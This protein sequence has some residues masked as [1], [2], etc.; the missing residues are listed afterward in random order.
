MNTWQL[1]EDRFVP[2]L[3]S[4]RESLFTIA[5]G[6]LGT[7]GTF[8]EGLLGEI[9]ATFV[10]GLFVTP[11]GELPMLGAVPDWSRILLW[12]DGEPLSLLRTPAGYRRTLDLRTGVLERSVLWKGA[13]GGVVRVVFRRLLSMSEPRLAALEA[14]VTALTDPVELTIETGID[15]TVGSPTEPAWKPEQ[16]GAT[17]AT[18]LAMDLEARDGRHRL[19]V[20]TSVHG[21]DGLRLVSDPEHP[22]FRAVLTLSPGR[23]ITFAKYTTFH[24]SQDPA[25]PPLLPGPGTTFDQ[26][27]RASAKAWERRWATSEL[28]VDGDPDSELALRFAAFQLIGAAAPN[29]PG[30]AIGAKLMSGFGYR[31]HVFW[32]TDIFVVPYFTVT[33]PDLARGHLGYRYRG[34][35]GARRKAAS[36]GRQGAFYAWESADTGDETT[37]EWSSPLHGEQVRIWTGELEEHIVADVAYTLDHYWRWSG[38]DR[39]MVEQGAEMLIDGAR[40]W[41]GRLELDQDGAHIRD[42]IGPDEYH[43]HVADSYFTNA[44]AAWHLRRAAEVAEW[45]GERETTA[46]AKMGDLLGVG[47]DTPGEWR[48]LADRIVLRR[49]PGGLWE[50]HAGFFDLEEVDLSAFRPRSR[51]MHALLGEKRIEQCQIVK[52]A[53]VLMAIALLGHETGDLEAQRANWDYYL[54]RTD[55]GSSLS[56]A[57]HSLVASRLGLPDQAFELFRRATLIDLEDS[58]GNGRDGLHAAT[59]GGVLQAAIFGFG[60]LHLAGDRPAATPRLP[61]HWRTFGFSSFHRGQRHEWELGQ[62]DTSA[63]PR[64]TRTK[65]DG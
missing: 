39:F 50:Q 19:R 3:A 45:L 63:T 36:Y 57:A 7:R 62:A 64:S 23:S 11:P 9:R 27:N 5:N 40:Y 13:D 42:V 6:Y 2:E 51:S 18:T 17:G 46:A 61:D 65:E 15:A 1:T 26:V 24:A 12:V 10:N 32:D 21:L 37:P 58:M 38:D 30:A 55:H 52:Q 35:A 41:A 43:T 33:Q 48:W 14:T 56:L 44:L 29:D 22:R 53:D 28:E 31:H 60:G 47:A 4:W 25:D 59:L 49:G 34:L 54:P 20:E 16:S 8:E